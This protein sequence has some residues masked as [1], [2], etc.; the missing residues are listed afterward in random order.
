MAA[1]NTAQVTVKVNA[2]DTMTMD[3]NAAAQERFGKGEGLRLNIGTAYFLADKDD[4]QTLV[5]FWGRGAVRR[6]LM[7]LAKG[8]HTSE[9]DAKKAADLAESLRTRDAA[10]A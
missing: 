9:S 3:F 8:R 1:K 5:D 6:G 2:D 10:A 4:R 7:V